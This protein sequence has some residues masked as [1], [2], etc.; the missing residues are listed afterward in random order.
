MKNIDISNRLVD[1]STVH[2]HFQISNYSFE[3]SNFLLCKLYPLC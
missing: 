1:E 3:F 2:P